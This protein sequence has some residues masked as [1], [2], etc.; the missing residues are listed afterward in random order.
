MRAKD[1]S[2]ALFWC[3]LLHDALFGDLSREEERR[4]LHDLAVAEVRFPD[5]SL[6][7]PSLSTL[8][9]KLRAFRSAG[10]DALARKRRSDRGHPRKA[11][12]H[13]IDRAIE[14]KR[15]QPRRSDRTI[16]QFLEH[17]FAS[18]LPRSTLYR[19]LRKAGATRLKLGVLEKPVRKRWTRDHTHALWVGDFEHGPYVLLDSKPVAT[20][21]SLFIDCHSRYVVEARYYLRENLD[22][23]SD[24]FVRAV[25]VHGPPDAVYVDNAKIYRSGAFSMCCL[26]LGIRR[27]HRKEHDPPGGGLVERMFRTIQDGFEA[28]VRAGEILTLEALNRALAAWLAVAYHKEAHSETREA[29]E[30]RFQRGLRAQRTVDLEVALRSFQKSLQRTV[31]DDFSDVQVENRFFRVDPRLRSDKVEVRFDPFGEFD[32]V[33]LYDPDDGRYLGKGVLY[34]RQTA[35]PA[36]PAEARGALRFR[37]LD[38]LEE[39]HRAQLAQEARGID[40]RKISRGTE[41]FADFLQILGR[42]LGRRGLSDFTTNEVEILDRFFQK[43]REPIPKHAIQ[44]AVSQAG[45]KD[46]VS[47]AVR[48]EQLLDPPRKES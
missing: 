1:E 9:R 29:P 19:H 46:V 35:P 27:L 47:I 32:T 10:F 39:K 23:L 4:F 6:K 36:P 17:E 22:V 24:S 15:D 21:L 11:R 41:S 31:H 20:H 14:L 28:E 37:Y 13:L 45:T 40:F 34:Q 16:R 48:L 2:S 33:F 3:H 42:N 7:R 38:L 26:R 30:D 12:S 43:R 25:T 44:R 8:K 5:G 18:A